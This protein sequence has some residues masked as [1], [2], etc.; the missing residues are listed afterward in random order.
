M[1]PPSPWACC[2]CFCFFFF[3]FISLSIS[4]STSTPTAPAFF[5]F[6][7][8][9]FDPG[10]NNYINTTTL[11]QSNFPPYGQ[12]YFHF[13]TGRF[14]D[15]RIIPDFILEYVKLPLI[16]PYM[17]QP[18]SRTYYKIGA[19]FAS[20]GAGALVHTFQGSVIS[21]QTQIRYHK[22]VENRLRKM[23]G[24]VEA[25]NTLSKAVYLFSIGTN[26]YLSPYLIT[27]STR[28]NSSYSSSKLIEIVIGNL[29]IA[30]KELHKRGGRKFGFLN[31]GPL[32]CLPGIRIILNPP[33]DSGGCIEAASLLAK[34]HNKALTKSLKR[35]AEELHGF[36]YLLYDFNSNLKHR[37]KHPSKYGYKEGKTACCGTGRFRGTFSCGG[38]RPVTE[39][40][41]CENPN[42]YVFWDSYH[43]TERVY[44]EMAH[45]IWNQKPTRGTYNLKTLLH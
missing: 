36:K 21:L 39:Y 33:T 32:G 16:P 9:F 40:Q 8:S 4:I 41:V 12:T 6:G 17:D 18:A 23:Y 10:N 34:L 43:L 13:P 15:G 1:E 29:T 44:K 27:N 20:A 7:D 2:N 30:I 24:N 3:F 28:F 26:D 22:R 5:I 19:N 35:L 14:S 42:E 38:K 11:D 31:L 45:Q 37:L 25:N